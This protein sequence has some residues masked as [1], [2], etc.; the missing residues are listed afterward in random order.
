M[1]SFW[2]LLRPLTDGGGT[3]TR[4]LAHRLLSTWQWS[5]AT[6]T[7][8]C[9]PA[10]SN[11]EIGWWLPLDKEGK[12][13]DLWMEAY[14][15]CLQ[16]V[17][18]AS[19]G[20][21]WETEGEG[22]VPQVS[23][24]VQAFLTT[25]GRSISPSS[26]RE[27]WPSK[28][29]IVPRQPMNLVR[30]CITHCLDKVATRSPS[31]IAWDM[32]AWLE[33]NKSFWKEDCLPY[34]PGSTVD[35]GTR[36]PGVRLKL[37]DREGNYQ[38]VARVLK[39]EGHMLIYNPQTNGMGWVAMKGVPSSLTKVEVRSAGD[40]GNFYPGPCTA[41]EDPQ[42]TQSPPEEITVDCGLSKT[43]MPRPTAGDVDAHIDWDTDD[44]QDRSRTPCPSAGIGEVMLGESAEDTPPARQNIRLVS[45]RVIEPGVVLPQENIP[46]IEEDKSQD[47]DALRTNSSP[48]SCLKV[49][50]STC[51]RARRTCSPLHNDRV[52]T[53][54]E[55]FSIKS[56][57]KE[58]MLV[59]YSIIL[60]FL[61]K[62][63]V[64]CN[65]AVVGSW[66]EGVSKYAGEGVTCGMQF[67][68]FLVK[69][70]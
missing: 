19:T 26:M 58:I 17:A 10:P 29:D 37:H 57:C 7:V 25:M 53:T 16:R 36:M 43:E 35:L 60:R 13:E 34:S 11:M 49:M 63:L 21:S 48:H 66:N 12:K 28:N 20:C 62:V 68:Y 4:H 59:L 24:V 6:H 40:L 5:S 52:G 64:K 22:M 69:C 42:I 54:T 46:E 51:S 45:E 39:Y 65:K 15:C 18:E 30:A 32:F 55:W 31:T 27:C 8:S 41:Q 3:A 38:G 56:G 9:P 33:S 2:P 23:P 47:D 70:A 61:S 1:I 67:S 44:V 50:W 14:A